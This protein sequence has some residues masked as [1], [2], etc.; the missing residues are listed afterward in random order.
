MQ[1]IKIKRDK[2]GETPLFCCVHNEQLFHAESIKELLRISGIKPRIDE[3]GIA[4]ITLLGPGRPFGNAVLSG[5][6][7]LPPGYSAEY[8]HG[9][10]KFT[11]YWKPEAK[12]HNESFEETSAT[13]RQMLTSSVKKSLSG[14]MNDKCLFLSGGLDSSI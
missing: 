9:K 13:V 7:E 4:A 5:I 3:E 2:T 14:E 11:Q 1:K 8:H 12:E 10:L 6:K